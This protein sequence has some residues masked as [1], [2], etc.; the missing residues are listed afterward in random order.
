MKLKIE[1]INFNDIPLDITNSYELLNLIEMLINDYD[2]YNGKI[3]YE[4]FE[5]KDLSKILNISKPSFHRKKEVNLTEKSLMYILVFIDELLVEVEKLYKR[6]DKFLKLF[7]HGFLY[8]DK[9]SLKLFSELADNMINFNNES[10][11]RYAVSPIVN[12][13]LVSNFFEVFEKIRFYYFIQLGKINNFSFNIFKRRTITTNSY[14]IIRRL[15]FNL[16]DEEIIYFY[17]IRN[18]SIDQISKSD[19][20]MLRKIVENLRKKEK[21]III[22]PTDITDIDIIYI[23]EIVNCLTND[24]HY[25]SDLK[26]VNIEKNHTIIK[27]ESYE[28][29]CFDVITTNGHIFNCKI[30]KRAGNMVFYIFSKAKILYKDN[31]YSLN[32]LSRFFI[33]IERL[34]KLRMADATFEEF[35]FN[36]DLKGIN[37]MV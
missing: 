29:L 21:Y 6:S 19:L 2:F 8:D 20:S 11:F 5:S 4:F 27:K 18:I 23:N 34:E 7:L 14:N 10:D 36:N 37:F 15:C 3:I 13:E 35:G 28:V 22:E 25:Y 31:L 17:K 30:R 26:I 16:K 24:L 9:I 32:D 1:S 33:I 12:H